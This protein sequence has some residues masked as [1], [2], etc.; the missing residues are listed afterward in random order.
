[1]PINVN[2]I[3]ITYFKTFRFDHKVYTQLKMVNKRNKY[4]KVER[5]KFKI[6]VKGENKVILL[7]IMFI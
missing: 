7:R 5:K 3:N 6:P 4:S 1:M 2:R